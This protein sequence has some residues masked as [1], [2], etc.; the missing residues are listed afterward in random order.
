[1]KVLQ[2][3]LAMAMQEMI[4]D[5]GT[6][7]KKKMET[8]RQILN[9]SLSMCPKDNGN[10]Q[11]LQGIKDNFSTLII[12]EYSDSFEDPEV[13]LSKDEVLYR[14]K[15]EDLHGE[16]SEVINDEKLIPAWLMEFETVQGYGQQGK[17]DSVESV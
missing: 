15:L 3:Q 17:M 9:F 10:Y 1:M 8:L 16:V 4:Q 7:L 13:I 6:D 11:K 5:T 14:M 2:K 12:M